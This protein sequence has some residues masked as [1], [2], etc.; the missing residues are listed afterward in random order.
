MDSQI[1]GLCIDRID[2][3]AF[4]KIKNLS[5]SPQKGL[6]LLCAP[7][8][9][10]KST[11]AGFIKFVFYGFSG[12]RK[13]SISEN[14]KLLQMP[15]GGGKAAG[16]I[17]ITTPN[18]KFRVERTQSD[19]K[20]TVDV[21]D[22]FTR[23]S[24]FTGMVPGEVFFGVGEESFQKVLFFKQLYQ[25][26]GGDGALAEQI[27]NLM[28]SADEKTSAERA[29]KRLKEAKA[30]LKNNQNRGFIPDLE[31]RLESYGEKLTDSVETKRRL[32]G[33]LS[34]LGEKRQKIAFNESKLESLEKEI[35]NIRKYE[36]KDRLDRL[37]ALAADAL[38][39]EEKYKQRMACFADSN[40]PETEFVNR[41][42][43]DYAEYSLIKKRL[44]ETETQIKAQEEKRESIEK[45]TPFF[46]TDIEKLKKSLKI[47]NILSGVLLLAAALG[48]SLAGAG[49]GFK[50]F[51][52]FSHIFAGAGAVF[53]AVGFF[54]FLKQPPALK[55]LGISG[56][57]EFYKK[58]KDFPIVK[59]KAEEARNQL[60]SL[61]KSYS[62]DAKSFNG[63]KKSIE[64]RVKRYFPEEEATYGLLIQK[65]LNLSVEAGEL[66]A[67]HLSLSRQLE[68][69]L[70]GVDMDSLVSL[71]AGAVKPARDIAAVEQQIDFYKHAN[72][73]L[74]Q[75]EIA[76]EKQKSALGVSAVSP[77]VIYSK[78]EA[79]KNSLN[80]L[81]GKFKSLTLALEVLEE[82]GDYMKAT[83]SPKLAKLA[84]PCFSGITDGKYQSVRLSTD[85][86]MSIDTPVGEKS[87][88]YLSAG[89]KD[90]AYLCLRQALISLLYGGA[91]PFIVLDD[92]LSRVD[93]K[94]LKKFL[95][96]LAGLSE[97]QQIFILTCHSREGSMLS[98]LGIGF[99]AL[100]FD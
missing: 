85:L 92:A 18:G 2:I 37:N 78:H 82:S 6:N 97:T 28:F 17:T 57:V 22:Y 100:A 11:L 27:Q 50:L 39:A 13:Q 67:E 5:I 76:L 41:L 32:D 52:M 24:L 79:V 83:I 81:N 68:A 1:H 56:K 8:E 20:E 23:K 54:L 3:A 99:N 61:E 45:S 21:F 60:N 35:V 26:K 12:L 88:D 66:K 46:K 96:T 43:N 10:G 69:N 84:S 86:A 38:K 63:L 42:I 89:T 19:T 44:D 77:A 31:A 59:V 65:M 64:T 36:A 34:A 74:K 91:R 94:R 87:A 49:Y 93:D 98:E 4:G 62:E 40:I 51:G 95:A 30:A 73:G 71:A 16:A 72:Q 48:L 7:N 33:V 55:K 15:W 14:E 75:Q 29:A 70:D 25:P 80:S 90:M 53:G 9:A 47:R 58:A